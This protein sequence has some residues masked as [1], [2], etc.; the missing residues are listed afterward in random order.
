VRWITVTLPPGS[1]K[2]APF[3]FSDLGPHD[4]DDVEV[5]EEPNQQK[6]QTS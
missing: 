2:S 6:D 4:P 5:V 1:G 3:K